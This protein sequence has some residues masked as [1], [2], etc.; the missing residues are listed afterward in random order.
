[1]T[2]EANPGNKSF[3]VVDTGYENGDNDDDGGDK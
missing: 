2:V 3:G 1:M